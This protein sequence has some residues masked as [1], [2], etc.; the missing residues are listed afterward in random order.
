L[1]KVMT[2]NADLLDNPERVIRRGGNTCDEFVKPADTQ[3]KNT[4]ERFS[5]AVTVTPAQAKKIL[6]AAKETIC[7]DK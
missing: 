4:V 5:G 3:V 1:D 7:K 6:A 2:I